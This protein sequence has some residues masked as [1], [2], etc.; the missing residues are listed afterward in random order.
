MDTK[1]AAESVLNMDLS[2]RQRAHL[3]RIIKQF[4]NQT[5]V[6]FKRGAQEHGGDLQDYPL[7]QLVDEAINEAIDQYV[8]LTTL[9]ERLVELADTQQLHGLFERQQAQFADPSEPLP[10]A[11]TGLPQSD[12]PQSALQSET[13]TS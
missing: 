6:K 1:R 3:N 10:R 7:L 12:V 2:D 5:S 9:R 13:E 11:D 8:Y 4:I